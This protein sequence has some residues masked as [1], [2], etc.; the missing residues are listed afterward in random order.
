MC[1]IFGVICIGYLCILLNICSHKS[2]L[3]KT[4]QKLLSEDPTGKVIICGSGGGTKDTRPLLG[5]ISLIPIPN[6]RL[7]LHLREI[8]DP[9]LVIIKQNMCIESY[10]PPANEVCEGYVFTCVCHS[11]HREGVYLS[12]CWDTT[13]PPPSETRHPPGSRHP[14]G[15]RHPLGAD[16]Q[17]PGTRHP[18]SS[19]CWEIR[20]TSRR[21]VSYWNTILLISSNTQLKCTDIYVSSEDQA[22]RQHYHPGGTCSIIGAIMATKNKPSK[23]IY[24][25]AI[26]QPI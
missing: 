11:V 3:Q 10:L 22:R 5:P 24:Y 18:R 6:S 26:N 15:T 7:A 2:Q 25:D 9:P 16:T 1:W 14:P 4:N 19:A 13:N 23:K 17:P 21:Y 20:S 8:L 12:A